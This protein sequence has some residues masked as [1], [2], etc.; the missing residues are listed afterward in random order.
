MNDSRALLDEQMAY[1]RARAPEYDAWWLREGRYDHGPADNAAWHREGAEVEAA[2]NA[3]LDVR[4]PRRALELACGTGL[5]TRHVAPRVETLTALDASPEVLALNCS[6]LRAAGV[7]NVR[8]AEADLFAWEPDGHY[9]LVF[10]SFWLSHVPVER[11]APFW[12]MVAAALAPG[13]CAYVIDSAHELASGAVDHPP[14]DAHSGVVSRKLDDGSTYRIVKVFWTPA[15]LAER[16]APLG[17]R[18]GLA[19]T[20]RYFIH[21]PVYAA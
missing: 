12:S 2:L 21:G 9:D 6:R 16:L 14:P 7:A 19:Q 15:A 5:F 17:F 10:M 1:Y 20:A 3:F 4:K 8:H 13:G 18:A 11:M